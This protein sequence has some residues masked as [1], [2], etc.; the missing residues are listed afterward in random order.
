MPAADPTPDP[1]SSSALALILHSSWRIL[2][3]EY[4]GEAVPDRGGWLHL[5]ATSFTLHHDD[6]APQSGTLTLDA[7][8]S[9]AA[10]DLAWRGADG[11]PYR[12]RAI[13][14]TRGE[15]MQFCYFP[16]NDQGRPARFD[17]RAAN[18][19]QPAIL[20]RCRRDRPE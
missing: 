10:L 14:R 7:A 5:A 18:G 2:A 20:V 15:L 3:V 19:E 13:V 6:T 1:A 11:S 4:A 12:L 16:A 9:P 17:S 8:A